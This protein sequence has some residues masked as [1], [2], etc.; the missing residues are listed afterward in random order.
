MRSNSGGMHFER[1]F[2]NPL[3]ARVPKTRPMACLGSHGLRT[4]NAQPGPCRAAPLEQFAL[5]FY[6][7]SKPLSTVLQEFAA[8]FNL[9]LDM[10][11][12][13]TDVVSG[14]FNVNSP[15]EFIDRLAGTFGF[16][17]FTY[18]GTLYVSGNK[19]TVVRSI[20][21]NN[22]GSSGNLRQMMNNLGLLEP[23]LAGLNCPTK[24]WW[25]FRDHRLMCE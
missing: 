17:W 16:N 4:G 3:A 1:F 25:W 11:K 6:S 13:M 7:E 19:D 2:T 22:S 14:R 18:A 21:T 20:L 12:D 24:G 23:V 10:P 15:T 8:S 5:L 9:S